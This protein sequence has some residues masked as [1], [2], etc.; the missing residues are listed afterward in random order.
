MPNPDRLQMIQAVVERMGHN[1]F[2]LKGWTVTLVAVLIGLSAEKSNVDFAWIAVAVS[3][4]LGLLDAYY[5]AVERKYRN[6]YESVVGEAGEGE[7]AWSLAVD[8]VD[9]TDLCRALSSPTVWAIHG[10]ALGCAIAV[11]LC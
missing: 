5:L 1:S 4:V 6:L 3:M 8:P 9:A 11:A 10:G 7:G 2:L